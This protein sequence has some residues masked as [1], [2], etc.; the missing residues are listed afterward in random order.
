MA[1]ILYEGVQ[2]VEISQEIDELIIQFYAHPRQRHW[3]FPLDEALMV[4]EQAKNN[5]WA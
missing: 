3:E 5:C 4:L 2:W 1:E